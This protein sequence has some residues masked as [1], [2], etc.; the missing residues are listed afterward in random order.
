MQKP[1][2]AREIILSLKDR[3]RPEK[4][5]PGYE[6][7]FHFDISGERGGHYTIT[8]EDG[9]IDVAEGLT[10]DAKC[11]VTAKDTVYEDVEWERTNPQMAFM[12]GKVKVSDLGEML[13]FAGL[14][15]RC[16]KFY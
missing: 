6:T 12:L 15:F 9:K 11:L 1:E 14:F 10:G 5:E 2:T 7:V 16:S 13:D 4:A 8:I 3:F